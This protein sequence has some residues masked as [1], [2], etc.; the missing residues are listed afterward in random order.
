MLIILSLFPQAIQTIR[1]DPKMQVPEDYEESVRRTDAVFKYQLVFDPRTKQLV[2]LNN[3][4]AGDDVSEED[5]KFAGPYPS[6]DLFCS[7]LSLF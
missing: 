4:S 6:H 2:H 5:L 7:L 3:T 1:N